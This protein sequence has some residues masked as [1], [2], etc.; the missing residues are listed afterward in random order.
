MRVDNHD[1]K[2]LAFFR[3]L[4][5]GQALQ[6]IPWQSDTR[7]HLH[8]VVRVEC[9]CFHAQIGVEDAGRAPASSAD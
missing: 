1:V 8:S 2:V 9:V 3:V 6:T 4:G 7:S 5:P